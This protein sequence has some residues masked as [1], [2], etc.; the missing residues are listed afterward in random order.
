MTDAEWKRTLQTCIAILGSGDWDPYLSDSWAAFTTFSALDHGVMYFNCGF[1]KAEDLLDKGTRDGGVWRQPFHY[2]DLAHLLVP[3]K[4]YWE[5]IQ[6]GFENGY[7]SQ[8]IDALSAEL[9][10]REIAH[11]VNQWVLEIKLY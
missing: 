4:F 7:K 5:R 9:K 11:A 8:D 1:P 10:K 6:D 3:R 2:D